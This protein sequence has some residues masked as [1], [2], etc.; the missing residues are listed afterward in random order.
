MYGMNYEEIIKRDNLTS[1]V[2]AFLEKALDYLEQNGLQT[3]GIFRV[4]PPKTLLDDIKKRIDAGKEVKW[5]EMEDVHVVTGAV[6]LFLR[7]LPDPLLTFELYP[8]FVAICD[9]EGDDAKCKALK[10]VFDKLP[11]GNLSFLRKIMR[12]VCIIEQYKEI[13]KMNAT[14]LS[15]VLCPSM[16]YSQEPNPLTM[17][18]DIE[19]SNRIMVLMINRFSE[20]FGIELPPKK[21]LAPASTPPAPT[22]TPPAPTSTPP[23][24]TFTPP[25][26]TSWSRG[27]APPFW[28]ARRPEGPPAP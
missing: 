11:K 26:P 7:E 6:K 5:E 4:S 1:G 15:V 27:P 28:H 3:T 12:L 25:P 13:N 18:E 17:V 20:L 19:K 24:P 10:K 22:S 16:L 23:A 21:A 2:P 14:N 8:D 9:T